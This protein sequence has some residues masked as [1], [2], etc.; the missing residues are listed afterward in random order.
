MIPFSGSAQGPFFNGNIIGIGVD[1][2]RISDGNV[3]LSAR[4]MLEGTDYVNQRC[5]IFIENSSN[6][7]GGF[8]PCIV[9]DSKALAVWES[10]ELSSEILPADGGVNVKIY[11]NEE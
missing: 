7:H 11:I 6:P 8:T 3:C 5:R 4:Y 2:Q 10:S 9:T 1:T